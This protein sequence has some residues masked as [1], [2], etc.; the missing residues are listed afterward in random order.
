MTSQSIRDIMNAYNSQSK[1]QLYDDSSATAENGGGD[2]S[3]VKGRNIPLAALR[4]RQ[5]P[6][7]ETDENGN[8]RQAYRSRLAEDAMARQDIMKAYNQM[9]GI[10]EETEGA[11]EGGEE[12][13]DGLDDRQPTRALDIS[14]VPRFKAEYIEDMPDDD[15]G[16]LGVLALAIRNAKAN[17]EMLQSLYAALSPQ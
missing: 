16:L 17:L 13:M 2:I 3:G 12:Y 10:E 11:A 9:R 4:P 5:T 14:S 6:C 1:I 8:V 7:E 15:E